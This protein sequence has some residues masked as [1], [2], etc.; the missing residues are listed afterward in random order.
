[1]LHQSGTLQSPIDLF[2]STTVQVRA[3]P[4]KEPYN[5]SPETEAL[6][7]GVWEQTAHDI[8]EACL[9]TI[10]NTRAVQLPPLSPAHVGRPPIRSPGLGDSQQCVA[11]GGE[12]E[13][14]RY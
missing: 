10:P 5:L 1:M 9:L 2:N 14:D 6:F 12:E 13:E 8:V 11:V 3:L 7:F 4:Q